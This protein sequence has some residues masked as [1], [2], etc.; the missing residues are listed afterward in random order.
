VA[1]FFLGP[2]AAS[3]AV[4][5]LFA[6]LVLLLARKRGRQE[7]RPHLWCSCQEVLAGNR[8]TW[9]TLAFPEGWLSGGGLVVEGFVVEVFDGGSLRR[10]RGLRVRRHLVEA[11]AGVSAVLGLRLPA[12]DSSCLGCGIFADFV[13]A[14]RLASTL[15][16]A[17][18]GEATVENFPVG[19]GL[20]FDGGDR[21]I[22]QQ[23]EE[24]RGG[25]GRKGG[26]E[27]PA[28]W[29]SKLL[30]HRHD[31]P[32]W[33]RPFSRDTPGRRLT[34]T[35]RDLETDRRPL[36]DTNQQTNDR[37]DHDCQ[38]RVARV[39]SQDWEAGWRVTRRCSLKVIPL[40]GTLPDR[41]QLAIQH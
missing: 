23:Q 4:Q 26:R 9:K 24:S 11:T 37:I 39:R 1:F 40:D 30:L 41:L 20:G 18:K 2:V 27:T 10:R 28:R 5:Q 38:C 19:L 32:S 16:P 29:V 33:G 34:S 21:T 8:L 6:A 31:A 15:T 3:D 12:L 35:D 7:W 17:P 14:F 36:R 13:K 25:K 22:E